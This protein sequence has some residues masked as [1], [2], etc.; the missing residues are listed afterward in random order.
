M[1]IELAEQIFCRAPLG[2]KWRSPPLPW[3]LVLA[4]RGRGPRASRSDDLHGR[5]P[6]VHTIVDPMLNGASRFQIQSK[7]ELR[8]QMDA[9]F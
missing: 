1:I 2:W 7:P 6:Y 9:S 4:T 3:Y 8:G 5:R